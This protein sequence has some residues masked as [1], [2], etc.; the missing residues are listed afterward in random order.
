[1]AEEFEFAMLASSSIS[2][3]HRIGLLATA[4]GLYLQCDKVPQF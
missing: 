2:L 1:M 4:E 3:P